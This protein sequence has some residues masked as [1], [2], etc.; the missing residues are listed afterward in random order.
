MLKDSNFIKEFKSSH[1]LSTMFIYLQCSMNYCLQFKNSAVTKLILLFLLLQPELK[2]TLVSNSFWIQRFLSNQTIG[3]Y[4]WWEKCHQLLVCR[5]R[6]NSWHSS[7]CHHITVR[8]N[9]RFLFLF[10]FKHYFN[11]IKVSSY[12]CWRRR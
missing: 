2:S 4:L 6:D 10:I 1:S 3:E 8:N 9:F 12:C 7:P 5:Q 11:V